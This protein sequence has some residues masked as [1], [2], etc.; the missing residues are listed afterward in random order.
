ITNPSD[1]DNPDIGTVVFTAQDTLG[2]FRGTFE[3][4]LHSHFNLG[5]GAEKYQADL[6][7]GPVAISGHLSRGLPVLGGGYSYGISFQGDASGWARE[8]HDYYLD[9]PKHPNNPA[10]GTAEEEKF[11]IGD[12]QTVRFSGTVTTGSGLLASLRL[13]GSVDVA[14]Q[15]GWLVAADHL[16]P[17][18]PNH[19]VVPLDPVT[20]FGQTLN[21]EVHPSWVSNPIVTPL[22]VIGFWHSASSSPPGKV[23]ATCR[24]GGVRSPEPNGTAGITPAVP[25]PRSGVS[26]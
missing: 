11:F 1:P 14:N 20:T 10:E 17:F 23:F 26:P 8:Q 6:D 18:D 21:L 25:Q 13:N 9:D 5:F 3:S 4:H 22:V 24:G 15:G 19:R 12:H 16:A 2:N 7:I